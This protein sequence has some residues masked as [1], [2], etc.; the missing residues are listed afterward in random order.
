MGDAVPGGVSPPPGFYR[1]TNERV[2]KI[3]DLE[4]GS[5]SGDSPE[6]LY[7]KGNQATHTVGI[8]ARYTCSRCRVQCMYRPI[9]LLLAVRMYTGI[10]ENDSAADLSDCK[11]CFR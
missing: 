10:M 6:I 11:L 7:Q 8:F 1:T 3:F 2:G 4:L 9:Y 5:S